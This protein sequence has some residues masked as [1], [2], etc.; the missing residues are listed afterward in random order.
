MPG[1]KLPPVKVGN[2]YL[3][4]DQTEAVFTA[5]KAVADTLMVPAYT[6]PL[7]A[8]EALFG[9]RLAEVLTYLGNNSYLGKVK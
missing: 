6:G 9:A 1:N 8:D 2:F 5:L 3:N 4:A 7:S